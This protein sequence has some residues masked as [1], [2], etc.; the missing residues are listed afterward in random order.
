MPHAL[1]LQLPDEVY[2]PLVQAASQ[3][4][5]TPE[6]WAVARLRA[7][8]PRNDFKEGKARLMRHVGAVNLGYATGADNDSIDA[9]L[10]REYG[11]NHEEKCIEPIGGR[12]WRIGDFAQEQRSQLPMKSSGGQFRRSR[13]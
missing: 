4:G 10:G 7:C 2:R 12:V 8:T 3:A 11:S 9:D 1:T 5:V 13:D 6:E